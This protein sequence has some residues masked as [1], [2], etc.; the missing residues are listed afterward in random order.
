MFTGKGEGTG[1]H[2]RTAKTLAGVL[3]LGVRTLHETRP[4]SL[5][6][7]QNKRWY[8]W[9][10]SNPHGDC[11]PTDFKSVASAIS[12]HRR[13]PPDEGALSQG[14]T[15]TLRLHPA[16]SR[17]F[18]K[19]PT[20]PEA[21]ANRA[22]PQLVAIDA[23]DSRLFAAAKRFDR[24]M[25]GWADPGCRWRTVGCIPEKEKGGFLVHGF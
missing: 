7:I 15:L 2:L 19:V 4:A 21:A 6:T 3:A 8:R 5:V 14:G 24:H 1:G 10:D 17:R 25:W 18:K 22:A 20:R 13:P 11:S 9:R 16:Q 12:P 23:S